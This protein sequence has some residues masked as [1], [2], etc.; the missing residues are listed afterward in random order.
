[1]HSLQKIRT[2]VL[3]AAVILMAGSAAARAQ[4]PPGWI[5]STNLIPVSIPGCTCMFNVTWC[6]NPGMPS[7]FF[8]YAVTPAGSPPCLM[9]CWS[10]LSVSQFYTYMR[11]AVLNVECANFCFQN[12]QGASEMV[13]ISHPDCIKKATSLTTSF[14]PCGSDP[15]KCTV[16]YQI[17]CTG[18]YEGGPCTTV[19]LS[20]TNTGSGDCQLPCQHSCSSN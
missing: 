18:Q 2:T 12:G 4:C 3:L 6:K 20:R 17:T 16:T 7:E 13:I 15:G 5:Q 19:E 14:L 8:I 10:G 9:S 1:M 11:E